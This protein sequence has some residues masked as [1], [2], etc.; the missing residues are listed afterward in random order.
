MTSISVRFHLLVS[1]LVGSMELFLCG[2]FVIIFFHRFL[3]PLSLRILLNMYNNTLL[4]VELGRICWLKIWKRG[5]N[6]SLVSTLRKR[7]ENTGGWTGSIKFAVAASSLPHGV[8]SSSATRSRHNHHLA[9]S[10]S[11]Q[12]RWQAMTSMDRQTLGLTIKYWELAHRRAAH[13]IPPPAYK[14]AI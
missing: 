12:T 7:S 14:I 9:T 6:Y 5:K 4:T 10:T 8:D 3:E 13:E 1:G 11:S 2:Y